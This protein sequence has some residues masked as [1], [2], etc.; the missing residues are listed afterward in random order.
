VTPVPKAWTDYLTMT[1]GLEEIPGVLYD[2]VSYV[3]AVSTQITLFDALRVNRQDLSNMKAAGH[4]AYPESFLAQN[5]R[6]YFK[7]DVMSDDS[8][9]G[10]STAAVCQFGDIVKL[11]NGGVL[12]LLIGEKQYGPW[13]LWVLPAHNFVKGALST[14]SDLIADYGQIDGF[15][16]PLEPNLV[17][18]PLQPFL[19]TLTWPGGAVTL[20]TGSESVIPIQVL[21]DGKK[22]RAQQ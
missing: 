19:V 6:V 20:S 11:V 13:P 18:A 10:D 5:L 12:N 14:G 4:L 9:A 16:Y 15:L 7:T 2:T 22:A 17:L 3:S 8:G 1:P 21:F